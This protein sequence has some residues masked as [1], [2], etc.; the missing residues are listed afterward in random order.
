MAYSKTEIKNLKEMIADDSISEKEK[1]MYRGLLEND[2]P[3]AKAKSK[4]KSKKKTATKKSKVEAEK[5]LANKVGK[6][7][8]ECEDILEQY[9]SLRSKAKART[10]KATKTKEQSKAQGKTEPSGE[11]TPQSEIETAT[12][13]VEKKI[14][15]K[16]E[17]VEKAEKPKADATPK[18]KA[19]AKKK[20]EKVVEKVADENLDA[21][22]G[23]VKAI[24]EVLDKYDK[25]VAKKELVKLR[26]YLNK[27][28]AKYGDGGM[29]QGFNIQEGMISVGNNTNFAKGGNIED[30]SVVDIKSLFSPKYN[31]IYVG[32]KSNAV[33]YDEDLY[34]EN[35]DY[36][37]PQNEKVYVTEVFEDA[38]GEE[39][40]M[41]EYKKDFENSFA[42]GGMPDTMDTIPNKI[43]KVK[44][45]LSKGEDF[46][47]EVPEG[48]YRFFR[49]KPFDLPTK[50]ME[51]YNKK[52]GYSR[53]YD[54][55]SVNDSDIAKKY[56]KEIQ[57][58]YNQDMTRFEKGGSIKVKGILG[59]EVTFHSIKDM[60]NDNNVSFGEFY[61]YL[62]DKDEGEWDNVNSEDIVRM[63]IDDMNND[64]IDV[65]HI[66]E[67]VEN[68]PSTEELYEIWLGNSMLTPIPI[69]TKED[70][71]N[72]LE[73]DYYAKGGSVNSDKGN[74]K[75]WKEY[76][77]ASNNINHFNR[78]NEYIVVNGKSVMNDVTKMPEYKI[79]SKKFEESLKKVKQMGY[80]KGGKLYTKDELL[81]KFKGKFIDTYP[82]YDYTTKETKYEVRSVKSKIHE[83]HETP[84]EIVYGYAKG[85]KLDNS[86]KSAKDYENY[87]RKGGKPFDSV[88]IDKEEFHQDY[89]DMSGKKISYSPYTYPINKRR[90]LDIE[91]SNRYENGFG[92]AEVE[93]YAKGGMFGAGG[94]LGNIAKPYNIQEGMIS[95]GN[96]VKFFKKGGKTKKDWVK[97]ATGSPN[98]DK[99]AFTRKADNR[100]MTTKGFMKEV[101]SNPD[102]Y[103][104][105]TRRQAQFMK[106]IQ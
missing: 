26:D 100:G 70:L 47:I 34:D 5:E 53:N 11:K 46:D 19:E 52:T 71:Y 81:K 51:L 106:N 94:D 17:K 74:S 102:D 22:A 24:M 35:R 96:N 50:V 25:V 16:I 82:N 98:F 45:S 9:K 68:N 8:E 85:G 75:E 89:Y 64:D 55:I 54:K 99:G 21:V 40:V 57:E 2:K 43:G 10:K 28:I 67:V 78:K 20:V 39:S 69:N 23:M 1:D 73:L 66:E 88:V 80:A 86:F 6:T 59:N 30:Y 104:L 65:S 12:E 58:F 18:A 79:L 77:E 7:E 63:Y 105:K 62:R 48:K 32:S 44:F 84:E 3:K 72:A 87:L 38:D 60:L 56:Q 97:K 92:D 27:E 101:L 49:E 41:V 36:D 29:V 93:I 61:N 95:V 31:Q 33:G 83:N 76:Q 90:T 37:I 14:E 91:T 13:K 15:K 4:S 42:K 103:T